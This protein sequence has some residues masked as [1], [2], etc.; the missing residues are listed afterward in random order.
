MERCG[1][2]GDD[3]KGRKEVKTVK[4]EVKGRLV[5]MIVRLVLG[6]RYTGWKDRERFGYAR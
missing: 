5:K 2:T 3:S 1:V 4:G 6:L